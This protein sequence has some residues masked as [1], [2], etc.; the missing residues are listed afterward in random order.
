MGPSTVPSAPT[1]LSHLPDTT[2][3]LSQHPSRPNPLLTEGFPTLTTERLELREPVAKDAPLLFRI[4]SNPRVAVPLLEKPYTRRKQAEVL[5]RDS[6]DMWRR[7][8]GIRWGLVLK[9]SSE[10]IGDTVFF[11]WDGTQ[12]NLAYELDEP[13]QRK[14]LMLEALKETI[15]YGFARMRLER[16]V[17]EPKVN[18]LASRKICVKLGFRFTATLDEDWEQ[19]WDLAEDGETLVKVA[20]QRWVLMREGWEVAKKRFGGFEGGH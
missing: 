11:A 6:A 18:N 12:A 8:N 14:G 15:E 13:Y 20:R 5:L 7:G 4:R 19:M 2:S 1:K 10:L 17:A 9:D 16:V 3:R